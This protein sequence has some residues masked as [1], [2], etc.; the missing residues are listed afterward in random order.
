M[1]YAIRS[2]RLV[3]Q[4]QTGATK[5]NYSGN[6]ERRIVSWF[7]WRFQLSPASYRV[8]KISGTPFVLISPRT[9][10]LVV[11]PDGSIRFQWSER[12][13]GGDRWKGIILREQQVIACTVHP[14]G[15]AA[16]GCSRLAS[17]QFHPRPGRNR[18]G[19]FS[20]FVHFAFLAQFRYTIVAST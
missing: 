7:N 9:L 11:R 10:M 14:E 5:E 6:Y 13:N 1:R 17:P 8:N 2:N 12:I 19:S 20:A 4:R 3:N 16:P 18:C 15:F